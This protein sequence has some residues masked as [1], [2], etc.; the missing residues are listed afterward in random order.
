MA[1]AA[2]LGFARR[3]MHSEKLAGTVKAFQKH[4]FLTWGL[5]DE[6]PED[7]FDAQHKGTLPVVLDEA[8]C[9]AKKE[10]NGKVRISLVERA[11][12]GQD[13]LV[14]LYPEC[15][16]YDIGK[17]G[18]GIPELLRF[19]KGEL[20]LGSLGCD[21]ED[22]TLFVCAHTK[23][24]GRCGFCGPRLTAKAEELSAAGK[25]GPMRIRKC[26]H[27]GGHKYAGNVLVYGKDQ[28]HWYG[29]VSPENL[30][31]V[32]RGKAERGRLWRG[33]LGITEDDALRER[34]NQV[35][36]DSLPLAALATAAV[37]AVSYIWLR[38]RK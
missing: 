15:L 27:V 16:E 18:A 6:W 21:I 26:S 1:A 38:R 2:E 14:M 32:L 5:A 23:R 30:L 3:E 22:T 8:I 35:L 33:R 31:S 9:K 24:D 13:G 37:L 12:A 28:W 7:P 36:R 29:Y 25:V 20:P 10:I 4:I 34:R 11:A 19:L 17:D